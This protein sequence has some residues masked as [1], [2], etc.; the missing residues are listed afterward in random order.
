MAAVGEFPTDWRA[1]ELPRGFPRTFGGSFLRV[2]RVALARPHFW[3]PF[4]PL[5]LEGLARRGFSAR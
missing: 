5:K 1:G 4:L 3:R 2:A